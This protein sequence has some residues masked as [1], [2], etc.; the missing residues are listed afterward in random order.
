[1]M[2]EVQDRPTDDTSVESSVP[3]CCRYCAGKFPTAKEVKDHQEAVHDQSSYPFSCPVCLRQFK[4]QAHRD[5]HVRIHTGDRPYECEYCRM[6]FK[7]SNHL[8]RHKLRRHSQKCD[9]PFSCD[10]CSQRYAQQWDLD[11]HYRAHHTL[12]G[13][14]Q[15]H[16]YKCGNCGRAFTQLSNLRTHERRVN[17]IQTNT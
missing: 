7:Q 8:R 6:A 15:S 11:L 5:V 1:M 2:A 12:K 9:R 10:K 14:T 3:L 13:S 17:C 16:P 4:Q